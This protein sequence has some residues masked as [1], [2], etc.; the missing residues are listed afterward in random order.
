MTLRF[1]SR[2]INRCGSTSSSD[3]GMALIGAVA[4]LAIFVMLGTAYV[5]YMTLELEG[6]RLTLNRVRVETLA[7]GGIYA[8]IGEIESALAGDSSVQS[9]YT[10]KTNLYRL[11]GGQRIAYPQEIIV[12]VS[13][14][15][16]LVNVNHAP[17]EVLAALGMDQDALNSLKKALPT[18][19]GK[20]SDSRAWLTA[21]D[22]LL[23]RNIVTRRQFDA[24]Y[25]T[26]LTTYT[27]EDP[28]RPA[29]FINLNSAGPEV[30]S[31]IFAIDDPSEV[32]K[33]MAMRPF[34]TWQ[35]VVT[36]TGREPSSFNVKSPRYASREMPIELTLTSRCFR[37]R[38]E[39]RIDAPGTG[40]VT[41][42]ARTE[43][44]V[45]FKEDGSYTIRYWSQR[46]D[47]GPVSGSVARSEEDADTAPTEPE[48][49]DETDETES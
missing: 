19:A 2:K 21:S 15:S 32:S 1:N 9:S 45:L 44:V 24:I 33:L 8:A 25:T 22:D 5:R 35:D 3:T 14:E 20:R 46:P 29:H 4:M 38:S 23:N 37:L 17:S 42:T 41:L 48:D 26:G 34:K 7:T 18:G 10:I 27:A 28:N 49:Q 39:V 11:E 31:A 6:S 43:A 30:L 13:D 36:K 40:G 12:S 47:R 16:A